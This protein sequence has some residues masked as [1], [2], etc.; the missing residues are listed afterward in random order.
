[1]PDSWDPAIYRERAKAWRDKA[2][3]LPDGKPQRAHCLEIAEGYERLARTLE[4]RSKLEKRDLELTGDGQRA[5]LLSG[6]VLSDDDLG[7]E[8]ATRSRFP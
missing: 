1:M 6:T 3:S 7:A 4:E 5:G 8:P 2:A